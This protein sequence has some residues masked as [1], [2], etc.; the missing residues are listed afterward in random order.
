MEHLGSKVNYTSGP[1]GI[2]LNLSFLRLILRIGRYIMSII[3]KR[4]F[5]FKCN[6]S[7]LRLTPLLT[8]VGLPL[9][10]SHVTAFYNRERPPSLLSPRLD[11][12]V[13]SCFPIAWF[14]GFLYYTEVPGLVSVALTFAAAAQGKHWRAALVGVVSLGRGYARLTGAKR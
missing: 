7:Q 11:A 12:V 5:L 4:I 13:L 9:A 2:Q 3:L 8:L 14:F 1:V 6:L 10:L